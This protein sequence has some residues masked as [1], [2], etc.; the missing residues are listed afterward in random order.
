VDVAP[1]AWTALVSNNPVAITFRRAIG[2]SDALRAGTYSTTL[3]LTL[4][5][6]TP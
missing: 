3:T 4:S 5:T 1:A 2:A 6:T